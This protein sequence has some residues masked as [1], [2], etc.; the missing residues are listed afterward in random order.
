MLVCNDMWRIVTVEEKR[1]RHLKLKK[2]T[3]AFTCKPR[4]REKID[5][6]CQSCQLRFDVYGGRANCKVDNEN[7]KYK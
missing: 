4:E 5:G 1:E 2:K 7:E 3:S 6:I